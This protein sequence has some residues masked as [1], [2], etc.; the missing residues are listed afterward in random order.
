MVQRRTLCTSAHIS[1]P[2]LYIVCV[3]VISFASV[4]QG[5]EFTFPKFSFR[6]KGPWARKVKTALRLCDAACGYVEM[7]VAGFE[8]SRKC[9]SPQCYDHMYAWDPL[10]LGEVDVRVTSFKGCVQALL[11]NSTITMAEI[12]ARVDNINPPAHVVHEDL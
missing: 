11:K 3:S 4:G 12:Q 8:C 10:E 9:M 5:V 7:D 2:V 1:L 6:R